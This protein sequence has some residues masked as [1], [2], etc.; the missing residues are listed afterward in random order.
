MRQKLRV[1]VPEGFSL[2]DVDELEEIGI[3]LGTVISARAAL[4]YDDTAW[5]MATP[6]VEATRSSR[7]V[8]VEYQAHPSARLYVGDDVYNLDDR[9]AEASGGAV[10]SIPQAHRPVM[11]R[12][13]D[14]G[15]SNKAAVRLH[16]HGPAG[17]YLA[18]RGHHRHVNESWGHDRAG[19]FLNMENQ[20]AYV[21]GE[22]VVDL[23]LGQ[24]FIEAVRGYEHLPIRTSFVVTQDTDDSS[25]STRSHS[26]GANEAG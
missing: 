2:N 21:D 17:E 13:V 16:L 1:Q 11:L 6:V 8:V 24:V 19:E 12:F 22:C 3:D 4:E 7:E 9:I 25:S 23:P 5:H 26:T 14:Q 20:Y 10:V 18:P 15:T